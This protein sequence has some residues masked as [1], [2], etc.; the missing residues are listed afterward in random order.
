MLSMGQ[1][2]GLWLRA[3]ERILGNPDD[4]LGMQTS[5]PAGYTEYSLIL[6]FSLLLRTKI[7]KT[8]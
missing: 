4:T 8:S 5:L 1:S 7:N 6:I 2:S 3:S